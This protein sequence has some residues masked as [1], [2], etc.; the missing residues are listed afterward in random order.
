MTAVTTHVRF[1]T[2]ICLAPFN[3]P[4]RL[5]E[6]LAVL[7]NLSGWARGKWGSAWATRRTSFGASASPSRAGSR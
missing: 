3:H 5:A 1:G 7:D 4:I 2:D 6:D